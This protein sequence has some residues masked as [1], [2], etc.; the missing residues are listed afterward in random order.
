MSSNGIAKQARPDPCSFVIFGVTGDLTHR[1]VIPALVGQ[2][3][4]M[5]KDTSL[6]VLIGLL[7]LLGTAQSFSAR[8]EYAGRTREIFLFVAIVYFVFSFG[9]SRAAR[10]LERSGSGRLRRIG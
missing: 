4:T 2:F 7:D 6:V 10:Q 1:L 3:I 5:F 8:Q 9:M